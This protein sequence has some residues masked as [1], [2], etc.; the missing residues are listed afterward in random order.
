MFFHFALV[1]YRLIII[2][3]E[4]LRVDVR[5]AGDLVEE[6]GRTL[7]SRRLCVPLEGSF[8]SLNSTTSVGVSFRVVDFGGST[9]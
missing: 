2:Q 6:E 8:S 9:A 3:A 5:I 4:C 7:V 1:P